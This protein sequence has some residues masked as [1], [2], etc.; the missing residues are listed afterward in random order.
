MALGGFLAQPGIYHPQD[1]HAPALLL[2][3]GADWTLEAGFAGRARRAVG[4]RH[5]TAR[6]AVH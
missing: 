5:T 4:G 2:E 3:A 6:S 1:L